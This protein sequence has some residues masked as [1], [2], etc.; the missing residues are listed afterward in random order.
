MFL[1]KQ[2]KK[3]SN[4]K[5]YSI[6]C[7]GMTRANATKRSNRIKIEKKLSPLAIRSQITLETSISIKWTSQKAKMKSFKNI[8]LKLREKVN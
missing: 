5:C 4:K 8:K 7:R 3:E 1:N 6:Q 2:T